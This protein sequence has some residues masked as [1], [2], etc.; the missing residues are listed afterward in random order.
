M[1]DIDNSITNSSNEL[2]FNFMQPLGGGMQTLQSRTS[3]VALNKSVELLNFEF[4]NGYNQM[5]SCGS[6]KSSTGFMTHNPMLMSNGMHQDGETSPSCYLNLN[7]NDTQSSQEIP[8]TNFV[9]LPQFI[10]EQTLSSS[11]VPSYYSSSSSTQSSPIQDFPTSPQQQIPTFS[12]EYNMVFSFVQQNT[13]KSDII[14]LVNPFTSQINNNNN[15]NNQSINNNHHNN[16]INTQQLIAPIIDNNSSDFNEMVDK[17]FSKDNFMNQLKS[18]VPSFTEHSEAYISDDPTSSSESSQ[19]SEYDHLPTKKRGRDEDIDT[20]GFTVLSK[21]QVLKL[22]SKEIEEYVSK[23]KQHHVLT[24]SDEKEL[25]KQRRL[26]KNREYASQS[27]SRRKVYVESIESKLQK[28]NNECSNIKQQLTEIKEENRE[29]KKQ[30]FSLTQTLK[31]NP[32]LA[33]AFGKIFSIGS[34]D[35]KKTA[36]TLS[37]FVFF[38]LF[39]FTFLLF[40]SQPTFTLSPT[41]GQEYFRRHLLNLDTPVSM[42]DT[43]ILLKNQLM[44]ETK[45]YI[46]MMLGGNSDEKQFADNSF[47]NS[48]KN[49]SDLNSTT[50]SASKENNA[51]AEQ[52]SNKRHKPTHVET[53]PSS[54]AI[55]CA[56]LKF[57]ADIFSQKYQIFSKFKM[58][59]KFTVDKI[60]QSMNERNNIRNFSVIA[61]VDHGK[62]TLSDSL[63]ARAGIIPEGKAGDLRYMSAR[64]DE[65]ARGITIKSSSVSLH[66]ELPESAPLPAGSTDRQ[67]LLNLID[68]PGHVDFSS[69]VTAALRVTDG[70][71]VVVDAIEGVCVQTETVLRQALSERI[72]PVLFV[73]KMDRLFLELQ[74][75]PEDAYL[76]LRNAIEA[77]N[78]VVQMGENQK[79]LDPKVGNVGF[80][81]GYQGWG[82]TL[83]NWMDVLSERGF[84]RL[85]YEPLRALILAAKD[86]SNIDSLIGK[87]DNLDIKLSKAELELRGKDLLRTVMKK[88]LPADE[89]IL[90][91]VVHHLPSPIVA[92]RYRTESLYT[93][94]MDDECAKAMKACDPNGPVMMFVSK[95]IPFG[96]R[97]VAFGRVFSG[98]ITS[99]Q[100]V[101]I[102]Q[103][104]YDPETSPNDFNTKKITSIVLMMGR[105]SETIESCPCEARGIVSMK[106]SVSP[107]VKVAVKPKDPTHLPKLVEGI[108][109][110]IKTDP[111][112]Q[113]YTASTGEIYKSIPTVKSKASNPVVSYRETVQG[114]SP[115]CMANSANKHNRIYVSASP[116]GAESANQIESK[117]LDPNSNDIAGRTQF[118]VRNHSWEANEAKQIWSFGPI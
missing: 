95:M 61:H 42:Y 88:F 3:P 18:I 16:Q 90:S 43:T 111:A 115:V 25:K 15:N 41:Q 32:S 46:S 106:F 49:K 92:Q 39:T 69:E 52:K 79:M 10:D 14:P 99:G 103:P 107:V 2:W 29:L 87:L 28:T 98:T 82:F 45:R 57:F 34:A 80:G 27:R 114:T 104:S 75:A 113:H 108:R 36:A 102:L 50:K 13:P 96:E 70:A 63:V 117:E 93:G 76:A 21:D 91:M 105:K 4:G 19:E 5:Q 74:V 72:V 56:D 20:S 59:V 78:A 71:L 17:P 55:I 38:T 30:L 73:N 85:I 44:T 23:L 8:A 89:C 77:T 47:V 54:P 97:F 53:P 58:M 62:T 83:E 7:S 31:A 116:L 110:V 118:F 64:G 66:F 68:S 1:A 101:R 9:S 40:P 112:I 84:C 33:E 109:K 100:T 22:S 35:S 60:S 11:P 51:P 94:P 67:F 81:S 26:I 24:P 6:T 86:E 37:L 65:I 48:L 12:P